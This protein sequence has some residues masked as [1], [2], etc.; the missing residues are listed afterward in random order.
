MVTP[1]PEYACWNAQRQ[2]VEIG[3]HSGV[4]L[5]PRRI[6]QRLLPEMPTPERCVEARQFAV[7]SA[8]HVGDWIGPPEATTYCKVA[9]IWDHP[10]TP[11]PP[12]KLCRP[13][14]VVLSA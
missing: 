5:E 11:D 4:V 9:I 13:V 6:F 3:E 1:A 10:P 12:P 14:A 2:P 7:S 8:L